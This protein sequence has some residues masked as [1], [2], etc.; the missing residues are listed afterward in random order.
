M[1][2]ATTTGEV[3]VQGAPVIPGLV[4]R[5]F[6]G[7]ED[8]PAIL[9]VNNGSK[10]ADGMEHDLHTLETIKHTYSTTPN[11]DPAKDMLIAEVGGTMV[12][13][14]RV[15]WERELDGTTNFWHFGFVL[16]EWRGK[17]LGRAMLGWVEHRAREI[18]GT[19]EGG[20]DMYLST[21]PY[22][23]QPG[24]ENLL[25][26]MS[27]E[28]VRYE[29][30]METPDLDHIPDVPMPEGL[31]I[32]PVKPEDYRKVWEASQ[33][34]FQDHW[35]AVEVE[36]GDFER[37][38][39]DP[40]NDPN[41]WVVAWDGDKVAGSILNFINPAYNERTGRKLGYT[42]SISVRRPWR[43]RGLARAMLA[44][45][46]RLHKNLGMTQTGL[47]VDTQNPSGALDLYLS[48]GYREVMK[49][50]TYKKKLGV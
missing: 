26:E 8:Y 33:E 46:M 19:L 45:S 21:S 11:H 9:E 31:E 12:G 43:R 38:M 16:P 36:D 2:E 35:G 25:V 3:H 34:A 24:L 42:E 40:M 47:G 4:F 32:R 41:L 49:S 1:A 10:T 30:Y 14:T 18:A 15:F 22:S 50:T 27:Y 20:G 39:S 23:T 29:F 6:R 7:D 44:H 17:G 28:A 13:F 48:M 37:T 5:H